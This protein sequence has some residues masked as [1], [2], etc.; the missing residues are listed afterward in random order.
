MFSNFSG[1]YRRFIGENGFEQMIRHLGIALLAGALLGCGPSV[2]EDE[3][4]GRTEALQT[5]AS[6]EPQGHDAHQP[7]GD[8]EHDGDAIQNAVTPDEHADHDRGDDAAANRQGG[9]QT[10]AAEGHAGHD[11]ASAAARG[12][13]QTAV[14]GHAGHE[15]TPPA[16]MERQAIPGHARHS[17]GGADPAERQPAA[18]H[19]A[20]QA[21]SAADSTQAEADARQEQIGGR[22]TDAPDEAVRKL[23]QLVQSLITDPAVQARIET[24]P[25][26]REL[27]SRPEVR[28]WIQGEGHD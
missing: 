23:L 16:P 3:R 22:P 27:W 26:L 13:R 4:G 2:P 19:D 8:E 14:A 28:A 5:P 15:A 24:D 18:R 1:A 21:V 9:H 6:A 11:A 25:A 12:E 7:T 10:A 17:P 20:H